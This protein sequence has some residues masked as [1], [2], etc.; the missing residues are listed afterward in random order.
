MSDFWKK[1]KRNKPFFCLAPMINVT[2]AAF[3]RIIAKYSR[4]GKPG[5]GP[6]VFWTEFTS[7]DGLASERGREQVLRLLEFSPKEKPIIAQLFTADPEKMRIA[8][9]IVARLGFAGI[10][11]NMGCPDKDVVKNGAGV[12]LIRNPKLA[13]EIIRA[14]K[15]GITD[16]KKKIPVSVKTRLGYNALE[17]Q[18]WLPELLAEGI[19]ALTVHLRTK[20]EM[21]L[22]PAHWEL[23]RDVANVVRATDKDVVLIGNGDVESL[24]D[25][26]K[27]A[28]ESGFDGIMIGRGIFG[29]PWLFDR[30]RKDPPAVSEKIQ[31]LAEH[32]QL[33]EKILRH[34]HFAI[35]KKHFKAYVSGFDGAKE[36]RIALMETENAQQAKTMIAGFLKTHGPTG[37]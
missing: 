4:H 10:D 20:K 12:A 31:A 37:T 33:F 30:K 29:N 28:R 17:Y 27:K 24:A 15:L 13:R 34:R 14:A 21:S 26:G 5:G 9:R 19:D 3:R 7:A 35:M 22:V 8:A 1:M 2:D 11:I 16:A 36:L 6:D 23:A 32:A 25:G 18:T